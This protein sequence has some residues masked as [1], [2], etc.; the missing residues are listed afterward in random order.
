MT[1]PAPA[2]CLT[3]DELRDRYGLPERVDSALATV[4][5]W[6]GQPTV[7]PPGC[8]AM[9]HR[10]PSVEA[11]EAYKTANLMRNHV[12]DHGIVQLGPA[13]IGPGVYGVILIE[14]IPQRT[15]ETDEEATR[16]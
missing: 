5:D 2:T 12:G 3:H 1:D 13:T 7:L 16:G 4:L 11:F 6:L 8:Y 9:A 15:A 10:Y 14:P